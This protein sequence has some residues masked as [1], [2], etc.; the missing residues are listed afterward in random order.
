LIR[1]VRV[2]VPQVGDVKGTGRMSQEEPY[3]PASATE[4]GYA[5]REMIRVMGCQ[6]VGSDFGH[7]A[8]REIKDRAP[9][10]VLSEECRLMSRERGERSGR[11]RSRRVKGRGRR[12]WKVYRLDKMLSRSQA[13]LSVRS[14]QWP[15]SL[16]SGRC[17]SRWL[18]SAK[19]SPHFP[20]P[21]QSAHV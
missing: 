7:R 16:A 2:F 15:G 21:F 14:M 8:K 11:R 3:R 4:E 18:G 19:C 5:G 17:W 12:I 1:A 20:T 10:R 6:N 9:V 13:R